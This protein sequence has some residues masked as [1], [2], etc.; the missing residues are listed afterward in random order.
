M[1]AGHGCE[2]CS[3]GT[4]LVTECPSKFIGQSLLHDIAVITSSEHHL[5]VAGGILDQSAWWIELRQALRN[6]EALIES[7]RG[8]DW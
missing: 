6:E 2:H 1:C 4:Y 5:P 7:E 8:H 3:H